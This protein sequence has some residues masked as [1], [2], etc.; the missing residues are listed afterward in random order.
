MFA[1]LINFYHVGTKNEDDT[2]IWQKHRSAPTIKL[3]VINRES[4][5]SN[6]KN[7]I[8][9]QFERLANSIFENR[10]KTLVI[11]LVVAACLMSQLPKTTMDTS[12]ES[13]LHENDPAL[14]GYERFRDQFGRENMI[15]IALNPPNIFDEHFLA[16]LRALHDDLEENVPY[17]EDITS[18]VNARNTYGI[19]DELIVDDLLEKWPETPEEL[20]EIEKRA[21]DNPIYKNLLLS[22]D[23]NF[24]TIVIQGDTYSHEGLTLDE[25]EDFGDNIEDETQQKKYLT[26]EENGEM[27]AAVEEILKR[28]PFNNTEIFAGGSPVV[29]H[30]LKRVMSKDMRKFTVISVSTIAVFLFI[31]FRRISGILLPLFIVIVSLL[32]T[33]GLMAATRTPLKIPTQ[34]LPSFILAVGVGYSVHILAIFFYHFNQNGRKKQAIAYAMGHSGLAV[35]LTGITTASGLMSFSTA[36]VA[37]IAD[38]GIFAA[39]GVMLAFIY[40]VVLLPALLAVFPIKSKPVSGNENSNDI[41]MDRLLAYIGSIS[42]NYPYRVLCVA[43]IIIIVSAWGM[44]KINF[45]HNPLKWLPKTNAARIANERIDKELKGSTSMEIVINTGQENGLYE[46]EILDRL[47][48]SVDFVENYTSDKLS[49]GK[50]WCLTTVLKE[51]NQALHANDKNFYTLPR[52]KNLIAQEFLLFENSGS[53]DLED[54]TDSR[55]SMARFTIKAP[56]IDAI[57]YAEFVENMENHFRKTYPEAEIEVTGI[58]PMY[59]R[60]IHSA[61]ISLRNSYGYAMIIITIMMILLIGRIRI[62]LM[63]MIPNVAPILVILGIMGWIKMPMDLFSMMVGSIAIGL[64]VDDTIHF[65]HNFRRYLEEGNNAGDAV[66]MTLQTA[67]RAMLITTC[68]LSIGFFTFIFASIGNLYNFGILTATTIILALLSDYFIAPALLIVIYRKKGEA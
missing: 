29:G 28:H 36:A 37:P 63:S 3:A 1:H 49:V 12:T 53:D 2:Q 22:E 34:I 65:M 52:D 57:E 7:Q 5:L 32:S 54:L 14:K 25:T 62:G 41:K 59:V 58:I 11:V 15:V 20:K 50:A 33:F 61:I 44:L 43:F 19:E 68:V 40:T 64:A 18:L 47:E 66:L 35:M 13:F 60:I 16:D 17:L 10:Y 23:G 38:L 56:L 30:F 42:I 26:D 9:K 48:K 8:E 46:P 27:V 31:M 55:F 24:T 21:R 67:G 6:I 4:L 51:I 39:A 45:S